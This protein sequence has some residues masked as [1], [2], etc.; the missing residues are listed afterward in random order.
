MKRIIAV[1][2]AA[3]CA[4]A[5]AFEL[6]LTRTEKTACDDQGGCIIITRQAVVDMVREA[7]QAGLMRCGREL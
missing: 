1:I 5:P 6:A 3:A 4:N 2:L 7:H